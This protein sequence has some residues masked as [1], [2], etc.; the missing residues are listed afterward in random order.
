MATQQRDSEPAEGNTKP[1]VWGPPQD[2]NGVVGL[3]T[4]TN[5]TLPK[6]QGVQDSSLC[7][8]VA[9]DLGGGQVV[10]GELMAQL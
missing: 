1:P 7:N 9:T 4:V 5:V 2:C 8:P 6:A 10:H 3:S